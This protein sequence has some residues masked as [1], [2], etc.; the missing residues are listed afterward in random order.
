[1]RSCKVCLEGVTEGGDLHESCLLDLLRRARNEIMD[2]VRVEV[3]DCELYDRINQAL[4]E[5][6]QH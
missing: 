1:M 6:A 5:L 4:G 2:K 3:R